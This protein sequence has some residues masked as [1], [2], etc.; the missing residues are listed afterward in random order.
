MRKIAAILAIATLQSTA[1]AAGPIQPSDIKPYDAGRILDQVKE[2]PVAPAQ[3]P[4]KIEN[5]LPQAAA[6]ARDAGI[7]VTVKSFSVTGETVFSEAEL[8]QVLAPFKGRQMSLAQLQQAC[9]AITTLYQEKGYFVAYA[10]LPPQEIKEGV[11]QIAVLEGK[12]GKVQIKRGESTRISDQVLMR[13]MRGIGPNAV[14]VKDV[15]E[16]RLLL[17]NDLPGLDVNADLQPGATTGSADVVLNVKEKS[18]ITLTLDSDNYGNRFSGE[19]RGGVTVNVNDPLGLGDQLSLRGLTSGGGLNN[20]KASYLL[21]VGSYGT[22]LG[23]SYSYLH[24]KLGDVFE[25]LGQ[26]GT[27]Q[28]ASV[29]ASQPLLVSRNLSLYG[30]AGYDYKSYEDETQGIT[31]SKHAHVGSGSLLMNATDGFGGGG[32][33][34]LS[35]VVAGGSLSLENGLEVVDTTQAKTN[36]MFGKANVTFT[37]LQSLPYHSTFLYISLDGQKAFNNLDT[38][39]KYS[40]GG[41]AGVRAYP[42]GEASG[43]NGGVG[44]IELRQNLDCMKRYLP[45]DLQLVGFYDAG[46]AQLNDQGFTGGDT[47]TQSRFGAGLGLNWGLPGSF[48]LRTSAAWTTGHVPSQ[49]S[50]GTSRSP[51][52]WF[53]VVKWF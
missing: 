50:D 4:A 51:R 41:P 20:G 44:T 22:K 5:E 48:S 42:G 7:L 19:Y 3:K 47:S 29:F 11:I 43:D 39:E 30:Q 24:Y 28:V 25:S 14:I 9:A 12:V 15:L 46:I 38:T 45:G 49:I 8:Q 17:L 18:P 6:P 40:L 27:S 34:N 16:N 52:C 2:K 53:Q 13:G 10:Y 37:R 23:A 21:P 33:T 36:G 35:V 31:A 26:N 32:V 1:Y